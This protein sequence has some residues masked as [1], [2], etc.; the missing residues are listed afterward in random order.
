MNVDFV[1]SVGPRPPGR[2]RCR[3]RALEQVC[4]LSGA[5]VCAPLALGQEQ[6]R[7]LSRRLHP[8]ITS[9]TFTKVTLV[10]FMRSH[11][12]RWLFCL[13]PKPPETLDMQITSEGRRPGIASYF[14]LCFARAWGQS[15]HRRRL[16]AVRRSL[17]FVIATVLAA[18]HLRDGTDS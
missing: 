8:R 9:R 6:D 7:R 10:D 2:P 13:S 18:G 15:R 4:G 14:D 3:F 1:R 16:T 17:D 11:I 12:D 5:P